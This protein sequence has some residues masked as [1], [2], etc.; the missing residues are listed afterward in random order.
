MMQ[1]RMNR[2]A[3]PSKAN[4]RLN[5]WTEERSK[6]QGANLIADGYKSFV[7]RSKD[8]NREKTAVST[9][10]GSKGDNMG[11]EWQTTKSKFCSFGG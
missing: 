9:N 1:T 5:A 7:F 4:R 6:H 10:F 3:Q 2:K 11:T 8:T